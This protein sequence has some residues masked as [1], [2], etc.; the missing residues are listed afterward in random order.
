[1]AARPHS[2]KP[3]LRACKQCGALAPRDS[4]VCPLCGSSELTDSWEGIMAIV[5]PEHSE[6]AK[7]LGI[8]KP[9]VLALRVAGKTVIR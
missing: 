9:V 1:M 5:I 4:R 2:R 8:E 3:P 6:V 7:E